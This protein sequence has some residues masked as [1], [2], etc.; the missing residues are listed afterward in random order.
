M[1]I[2]KLY[3]IVDTKD[4][5]AEVSVGDTYRCVYAFSRER[6]YFWMCCVSSAVD[7]EVFDGKLL[8]VVS[9]ANVQEIAEA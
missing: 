1:E 7:P 2:G 9:A 8:Q 4:L 6:G 3:R 5:C